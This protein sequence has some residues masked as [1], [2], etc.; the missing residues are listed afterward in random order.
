MKAEP[1]WHGGCECASERRRRQ[2]ALVR[3]EVEDENED[4]DDLEISSGCSCCCH[5]SDRLG[6]YLSIDIYDLNRQ[7]E[8]HMD[9]PR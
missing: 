1:G 7:A 4:E 5:S 8:E 2:S 3:R 9:F 6:F